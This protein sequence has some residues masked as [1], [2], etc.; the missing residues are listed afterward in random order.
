MVREH[1]GLDLQDEISPASWDIL[2][3]VEAFFEHRRDVLDDAVEKVLYE[4][5]GGGKDR[6]T[7]NAQAA[8]CIECDAKGLPWQGMEHEE[9]RCRSCGAVNTVVACEWCGE[10]VSITPDEEPPYHHDECLE[11]RFER[12]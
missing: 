11:A 3:G 8:Y 2:M 10:P 4:E 6:L 9:V 5:V 1:A 12:F 7:S